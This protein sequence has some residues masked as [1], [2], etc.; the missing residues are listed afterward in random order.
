MAIPINHSPIEH[1][2]DLLRKKHNANVRA[3]FKNQKFDEPGGTP[4]EQAAYACLMR[5]DDNAETMIL[6]KLFFEF[7]CGHAQSLQAPVYGIP[8]SEHQR[9]VKF[10]P[11]VKLYFVE[12]LG[13]D[14]ID[15]NNP[16]SGEIT[17]RLMN[18]SSNTYSRAKAEA[19]AKDIKREFGTPIF[20]WEKGWFYYYYKDF[21]R[22]YDLR[23]LV[24]NK[25]EGERIAKNV[26]AIQGHPFNKD[27]VDF[28]DHDR[29][30]SLN[31]GTQLIYGQQT[32]KSVERPRV[33]VR[34]R[35]AQ[36]LL[37]G[38][39]KAINLVATPQSRLKQVIERLT[40]I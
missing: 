27:F 9:G 3:F 18:E 21:E 34:F 32:K 33:D 13:I 6:R 31:P 37:H 17:F 12:R 39:L 11:Q 1:F 4:K 16:A 20:N 19:M 40:T 15:R 8:V 7:D 2:H 29:T 26:L 35:Y 28:P 38:R 25:S 5:D 30:Y 24:K 36:L 14:V 10:K 23:L 22:G